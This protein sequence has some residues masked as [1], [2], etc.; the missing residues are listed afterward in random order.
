ML[1]CVMCRFKQVA[2]LIKDTKQSTKD[3]LQTLCRI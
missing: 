2:G 3:N 1:M